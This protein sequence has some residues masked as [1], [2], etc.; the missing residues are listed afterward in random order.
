MARG[1]GKAKKGMTKGS[2]PSK[3]ARMA[4]GGNPGDLAGGGFGTGNVGGGSPRSTGGGLANS[5]R[6][7]GF[8]GAG[9]GGN[10]MAS[11]AG[12]SPSNI[13]AARNPMSDFARQ[14][15][16][17]AAAFGPTGFR[18][19][20]GS[21]YLRGVTP[22]VG[23]SAPN[24]VS[25][26]RI[27]GTQIESLTPT[28]KIADRIQPTMD[29][30]DVVP[31]GAAPYQIGGSPN[32]AMRTGAGVPPKDTGM[33]AEASYERLGGWPSTQTRMAS[34]ER[35]GGFP[36]ARSESTVAQRVTPGIVAAGRAM[37]AGREMAAGPRDG[38]RGGVIRRKPRIGLDSSTYGP[39]KDKTPMAA[40]DGGAIR[41]DGL[42]RC[43]TK[44][45]VV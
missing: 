6:E 20:P 45:R 41:G 12:T 30:S 35:L 22:G 27:A 24:S 14:S 26:P 38:E 18:G 25:D 19:T 4:A 42:S 32:S 8:G 13:A 33:T 2:R 9:G 3:P 28:G 43:K 40:K 16:Q 17:I 23:F 10:A 29:M 36:S 39:D 31:P 15:T 1:D 37:A 34:Y 44:G 11:R 21:Q 7:G 5:S